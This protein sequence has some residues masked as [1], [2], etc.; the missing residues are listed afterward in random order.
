[1]VSEATSKPAKWVSETKTKDWENE[2]VYPLEKDNQESL[3]EIKLFDS[4]NELQDFLDDESKRIKTLLDDNFFNSLEEIRQK[5]E[6]MRKIKTTLTKVFG[7]T[8][9]NVQEK[10]IEMNGLKVMVN[11]DP[12]LELELFDKVTKSLESKLNIL[13]NVRKVCESL[14]ELG[15]N[16]K[17]KVAFN[18]N[19]PTKI[20][21]N[22]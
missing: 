7:S 21:L 15:N 2:N 12:E 20:I 1:M 11:P 10:E 4:I 16:V 8:K 6:K 18:D 9:N 3:L 14:S 22:V 17:I 19:I 13:D 5:A